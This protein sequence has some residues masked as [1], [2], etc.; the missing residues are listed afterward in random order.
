MNRT[1]W[2]SYLKSLGA[3][4][5]VEQ[6]QKCLR[7]LNKR[8]TALSNRE[9]VS[10]NTQHPMRETQ[11]ADFLCYACV[12][13]CSVMSHSLWPP[14]TVSLP[15]SPVSEIF[16]ARILQGLPFLPPGDL[17]NLGMEPEFLVSPALASGFF[18]TSATWLWNGRKKFS[19]D[20]KM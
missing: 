5:L 20:G 8:W 16:Q 1:R 11:D 13:S 15:D 10:E 6:V 4:R 7:N 2:L 17:P 18:T 12:L 9:A 14:S 19:L 3:I